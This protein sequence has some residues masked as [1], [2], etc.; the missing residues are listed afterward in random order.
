MERIRI[1]QDGDKVL[2]GGIQKHKMIVIGAQEQLKEWKY[3]VTFPKMDGTIDK[4]RAPIWF[5]AKDM[6][7]LYEPLK[8]K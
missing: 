6:Q 8:I 5:Y 3:K 4:R 1:Y 2:A 7:P